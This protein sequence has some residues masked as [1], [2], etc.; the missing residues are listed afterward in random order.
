M[1]SFRWGDVLILLISLVLTIASFSVY[2][3][4]SGQ[5]IVHVRS[6]AQERLYDLSVDRVISVEG[7]L[8]LTTIE[9]Q[10][11][12]VRVTE[13]A[14]RNKICIAAG[15]Q[16]SPG[17]WIICLPNNIFVLIEGSQDYEGEIDELA[18]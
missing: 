10:D 15:W 6:G 8:G 12:K 2:K 11:G 5:P 17:E 13:S 14:C 7:T 9:I 16:S 1:K 18:F 3:N 4:I